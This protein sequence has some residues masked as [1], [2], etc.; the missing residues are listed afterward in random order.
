MSAF[1]CSDNTIN[2]ITAGMNNKFY[3]EHVKLPESLKEL[4]PEQIG[5]KLFELNLAGVY[6]RYDDDGGG[7]VTT[8]SGVETRYRYTMVP[9]PRKIQLLKSLRCL[10]YQCAEGDIP[11]T[12]QLYKELELYSLELAYYIVRDLPEYDEAG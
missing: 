8:E 4:T 9:S 7:L 5:E 3:K 11:E 12:S 2:S 10:V 1:I 6:A